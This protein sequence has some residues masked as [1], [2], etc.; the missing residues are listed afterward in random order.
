MSIHIMAI[1]TAKNDKVNHLHEELK[2]LVKDTQKEPACFQYELYQDVES[3]NVF[4]MLE[5]WE[6]ED[7]IKSHAESNHFLA[8]L[9]K[10]EALMLN[11][12]QIFKTKKS[13]D[14]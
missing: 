2:S 10:S 12:L 9:K 13:I 4:I 7:G 14:N 1:L 11:P 3:P 5:E 6:N 8:F